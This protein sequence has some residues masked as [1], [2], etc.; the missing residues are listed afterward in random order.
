MKKVSSKSKAVLTG[1]LEF[2]DESGKQNLLP[3][4][5]DFLEK[6]V[7]KSQESNEIIVT[8]AVKISPKQLKNLKFV[9]QKK[10]KVNFPIINKIDN[11]L[12]GGFT[13][14]VNDWFLDSSISHQV[15]LLK[16]SLLE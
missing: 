1:L 14:R 7:A 2:L 12:L 5:A 16:R 8:S 4:V 10:L 6:E 9:M 13:I 15:E 3:E 11:N